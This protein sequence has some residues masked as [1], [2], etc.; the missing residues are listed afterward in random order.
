MLCTS[1][2]SFSNLTFEILRYF[3]PG[4]PSWSILALSFVVVV[5]RAFFMLLVGFE[6]EASFWRSHNYSG[7]WAMQHTCQEDPYH[8]VPPSRERPEWTLQP[9]ASWPA[10]DPVSR[11]EEEEVAPTPAR[12][13]A[14][15]PTNSMPH[16]S[17]GFAPHKPALW[18]GTSP[19]RRHP[20]WLLPVT[21]VP[22]YTRCLNSSL[23][24]CLFQ[25]VDYIC[26]QSHQAWASGG[27]A[28]KGVQ[29]KYGLIVDQDLG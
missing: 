27:S 7:K 5:Q 13:R 14:G 29:V 2:W 23:E 1:S 17:A 19:G 25:K 16:A 10:A 12:R 3:F 26:R 4:L 20:T 9:H 21:R 15:L 24:A 28:R 11:E 8:A 18:P 6:P 22:V